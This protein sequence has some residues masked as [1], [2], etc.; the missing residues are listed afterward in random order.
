MQ[1]GAGLRGRGYRM[2]SAG[3][4]LSLELPAVGDGD[5]L[6]G[7][8]TLAAVGLHLLHH[9]HPLHHL[10]EHH[11]LPIQPASRDGVK[12]RPAAGVKV[13]GK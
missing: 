13:D 9:L 4:A 11:V 6:R 5:L 8:A 1:G 12:R 10:A 2:S 3:V 7:F